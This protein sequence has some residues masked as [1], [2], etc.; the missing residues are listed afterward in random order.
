MRRYAT[1]VDEVLGQLESAEPSIRDAEGLFDGV[2]DAIE[3]GDLQHAANALGELM[4]ALDEATA[5][6]QEAAGEL[7]SGHS[8]W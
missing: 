1:D 7:P 5:Y 2:L 8:G 3:G 4:T 6:L